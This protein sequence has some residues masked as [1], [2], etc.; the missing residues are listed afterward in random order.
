MYIGPVLSITSMS[1]N[2]PD[3]STAPLTKMVAENA[4]S[5]S[6]LKENATW[7]HERDAKAVD[8]SIPISGFVLVVTRNVMRLECGDSHADGVRPVSSPCPL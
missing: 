6:L 5:V 7:Y 1:L 8:D 3:T 2:T 4:L